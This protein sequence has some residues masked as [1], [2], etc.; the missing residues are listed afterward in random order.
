[1]PASYFAED[2]FPLSPLPEQHRIVA[3]ADESMAL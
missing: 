3:K 2:Q 1:V